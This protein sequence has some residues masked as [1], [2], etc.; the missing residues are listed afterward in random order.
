MQSLS[1]QPFDVE[2]LVEVNRQLQV[3]VTTFTLQFTCTGVMQGLVRE[4]LTRNSLTGTLKAF[5]CEKVR[6]IATQY[7]HGL[8][9]LT[10]DLLAAKRPRFS[11][12]KKCT[13]QRLRIGKIACE[14]QQ[15]TGH[16]NPGTVGVEPAAQ[17]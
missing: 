4:Y 10:V 6:A 1:D 5:D 16:S 17:T 9:Q 8:L 14:G 7:D 13:P 3:A 2:D 15:T 12:F 11:C